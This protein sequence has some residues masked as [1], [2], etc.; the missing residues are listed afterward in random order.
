MN[1]F[2]CALILGSLALPMQGASQTVAERDL[3]R[4]VA[5]LGDSAHVQVLA[6]GVVIEDGYFLGLRLDSLHV[7]SAD[8][9]ITVG[10]DEIEGLSVEG[11][12]WKSL[13]VQGGIIGLVAGA[14]A[15]FFFGYAD[16]GQQ[17]DGCDEHAWSV[18]A[19]WGLAF[20]VG[21]AVAGGTVGSRL[22]T[23]RTVVP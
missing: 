9:V 2:A 17:L 11:S 23:W 18:A 10:L 22:R 14:T 15:G 3:R 16:C 7:A 8:A 4:V 13:G 21:G 5:S 6:P 1:R 20:G 19:R 12:K